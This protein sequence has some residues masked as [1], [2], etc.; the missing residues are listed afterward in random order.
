MYKKIKH[1]NLFEIILTPVLHWCAIFFL[2]VLEKDMRSVRRWG[3]K[4][5]GEHLDVRKT[6]LRQDGEKH[7]IKSVSPTV[8]TI[9]AQQ[10]RW[11][12]R[13]ARTE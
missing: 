13:T 6:T 4:C 1:E 11:A 2:P 3:T 9:N 12:G 5:L 8:G 10:I 7:V